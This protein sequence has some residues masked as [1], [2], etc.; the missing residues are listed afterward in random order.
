L[1]E[2]NLLI[3]LFFVFFSFYFTTC[4]TIE[5]NE[6]D[7]AIRWIRNIPRNVIRSKNRIALEYDI[8]PE[9]KQEK[10]FEILA[11]KSFA[12]IDEDEYL[13]LFGKSPS[14]KYVIAIRALSHSPNSNSEIERRKLMI[15]TRII[16]ENVIFS[17]EKHPIEGFDDDAFKKLFL[18]RIVLVVELDILPRDVYVMTIYDIQRH[19]RLSATKSWRMRRPQ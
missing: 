18:H 14:K 19:K 2:T 13:S 15:A 12:I 5:K 3:K 16:D 10:Y 6:F 11:N 17:L 8:I 4:Q 7:N 1:K 9:N